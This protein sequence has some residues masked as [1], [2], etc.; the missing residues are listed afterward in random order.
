ML[1]IGGNPAVAQFANLMSLHFHTVD[2]KIKM[3][4]NGGGLN[5]NYTVM[6]RSGA[7]IEVDGEP[8]PLKGAFGVNPL[9]DNEIV[10]SSE[11][12]TIQVSLLE[13]IY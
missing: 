7:I 3:E 5:A 6:A 13:S 12:D 11:R 10:L 9:G 2:G 8:Q 4:V 1:G